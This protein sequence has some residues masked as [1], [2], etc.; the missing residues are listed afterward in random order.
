MI[1]CFH[2]LFNTNLLLPL[3]KITITII[4]ATLA[5]MNHL[6]D[7]SDLSGII[8]LCTIL[9][10]APPALLWVEPSSFWPCR[11]LWRFLAQFKFP[12]NYSDKHLH[13]K[14]NLSSLTVLY[15]L[16]TST[17]WNISYDRT[18]C[19]PMYILHLLRLEIFSSFKKHAHFNSFS[20]ELILFLLFSLWQLSEILHL[21]L[22][23]PS[24]FRFNL[25]DLFQISI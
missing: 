22:S 8:L 9:S 17:L 12:H 5:S 23:N 15:L 2:H 18:Q 24:T 7:L 10:L 20:K 19:F 16:F 21:V 1:C 3:L 6:L 25:I 13:N 4:N 11:N 14:N